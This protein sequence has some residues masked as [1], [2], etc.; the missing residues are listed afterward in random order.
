MH[1]NNNSNTIESEM[2]L[3]LRKLNVKKINLMFTARSQHPKFNDIKN[4][5]AVWHLIS[6]WELAYFHINLIYHIFLLLNHNIPDMFAN[7]A[8]Q[9]AIEL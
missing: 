9:Y 5:I 4:S 2:K 1:T 7:N 3:K 6:W 8:T